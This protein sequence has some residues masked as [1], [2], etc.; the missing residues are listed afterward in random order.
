[1]AVALDT[2]IFILAY[3]QKDPKGEKALKLL[4]KIQDSNNQIFISVIVF[5]EFLVKIYKQGLERNL[6]DYEN[7]LTAGGTI[8]VIDVNKQIA[9]LAAKIRADYSSIRTPDAIHIATALVV[10]AKLFITT[11]RRLPKKIKNLEIRSLSEE[12][13]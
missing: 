7:F 8:S 13:S 1:M 9:R 2:N 10:N 5:E 11:D 3:D 6:A 4:N 12:Y